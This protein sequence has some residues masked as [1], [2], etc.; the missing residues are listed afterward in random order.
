MPQFRCQLSTLLYPNFLYYQISFSCCS[1][2]KSWQTA[3]FSLKKKVSTMK[4]PRCSKSAI[5]FGKIRPMGFDLKKEKSVTARVRQ[6]E[7][8]WI[9]SPTFWEKPI[10]LACRQHTCTWCT[11]RCLYKL[12]TKKGVINRIQGSRAKGR[13]KQENTSHSY[14][15]ARTV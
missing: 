9:S 12:F 5:T 8:L 11:N 6:V 2:I 3:G 7:G 13:A 15:P 4:T 1:S 14:H 10:L